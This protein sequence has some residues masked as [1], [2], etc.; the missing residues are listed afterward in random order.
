VLKAIMSASGIIG[1]PRRALPAPR[2]CCSTTTWEIDG[3]FRLGFSRG[4]TGAISPP[5]RRARGWRSSPTRI[6]RI[7][8]KDG[9][10]W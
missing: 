5:R 6:E 3:A 4:G 9:R 7:K 8:V 10:A 1:T 2:A